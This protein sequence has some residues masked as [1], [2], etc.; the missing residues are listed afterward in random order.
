MCIT[1]RTLNI[2]QNIFTPSA[3]IVSP[4]NTLSCKTPTLVLTNNSKTKIP[5]NQPPLLPPTL[6]VVGHVWMG[7]PPSNSLG[8]ST[9]Y[10]AMYPGTY[11]ITAK[12]L[13]NGCLSDATYEI[14]DGFIFPQLQSTDVSAVLD[15][16][17]DATIALVVTSATTDVLSYTW[18]PVSG[19]ETSTLNGKPFLITNLPGT[20]PVLIENLTSGCVIN[21]EGDVT[22]NNNM[23]ASFSTSVQKGT[24]PLVVNLTN[25]SSTGAGDTS[26]IASVFNFGN[27]SSS[28]FSYNTK[29][30][31]T[32]TAPGTYTITLYSNKGSCLS[33]TQKIIVVDAASSYTVPN[34]FTPNNDGIND[35]FFIRSSNMKSFKIVIFDRTGN[36]VYQNKEDVGTSKEITWD[37]TTESGSAVPSGLYFYVLQAIKADGTTDKD[38]KGTL[39]LTR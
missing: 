37:G 12:D 14:K 33:S 17:K 6:P 15:C 3:S 5:S 22:T 10:T 28:T 26:K 13:N 38:I 27:G 20:Y 19:A 16:G 32:Y 31:V 1:T 7:P 35:L 36:I 23:T 30:S 29:S 39:T 34:I 11:T 9:T 2:Y 18:T 25:N 21:A 24:A 4:F 8:A